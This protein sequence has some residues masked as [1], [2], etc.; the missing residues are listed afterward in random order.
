MN[1]EE[2]GTRLLELMPRLWAFAWRI[3]GSERKAE[4]VVE[5]AYRHAFQSPTDLA[6]RII[7]KRMFALVYSAWLKEGDYRESPR[8]P[9]GETDMLEHS[10]LIEAVQRLPDGPRITMLLAVVE[11][12]SYSDVAFILGVPVRAVV[13]QLAEAR[14]IIGASNLARHVQSARD[15]DPCSDAAMS[16]S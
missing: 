6:N 14:Q 8:E 7:E 1:C 16:G 11:G 13:V 5:Q 12:F 15:H 9:A 4:Y 2:L 10:T 3:S